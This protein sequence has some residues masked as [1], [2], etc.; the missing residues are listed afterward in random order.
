MDLDLK[1]NEFEGPLDLLLHLIKENKMNIFD[2]EIEKITEQYLAY[3]EKQ[4]SMNLEVASEYLVLASELI[5]IKSKLLLPNEKKELEENDDVDPREELVN[6]LLEYEAYKK[7]TK[8]L[9]EKELVR[10]TIYTKD[11]YDLK[12]FITEDTNM[13]TDI[14]LNDLVE[15]FKKFLER[16]QEEKPLTTKVTE[17]EITVSS[18]RHDIKKIL[19]R[20]KKISF[21]K[22]FPVLSK[23]YVVS[24]FLAIL[25]MAKSKELIITQNNTFD[26]II[27]EVRECE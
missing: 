18:R 7:V 4:E 26:D 16:K 9:K 12:E 27:C 17:K 5:E 8:E 11:P 10:R 24:T 19:S 14:D 6:R 2:I 1:I 15:A 13:I 23:E 3:I 25:E 21:F 20:E 22:L